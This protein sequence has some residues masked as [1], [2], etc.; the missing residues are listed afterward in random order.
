MADTVVIHGL[1]N[2]ITVQAGNGASV[3][4]I[5]NGDGTT[6]YVVP[7]DALGNVTIHPPADW[8]GNIPLT[9]TATARDG[10]WSAASDPVEPAP[11]IEVTPVTETP[12]NNGI[13]V[14]V[15]DA[16]TRRRTALASRWR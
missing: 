15:V 7:V 14:S 6:D 16:P 8:A 2:D 11:V 9:I 10:Y 5:D 3:Y 12:G 13:G 4:A 1:S